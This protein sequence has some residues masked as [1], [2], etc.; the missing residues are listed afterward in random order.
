MLARQEHLHVQHDLVS[1]MAISMVRA[2][3][4]GADTWEI[5][6]SNMGVAPIHVQLTK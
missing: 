6:N 5:R 1:R 4:V 3:V 2:S